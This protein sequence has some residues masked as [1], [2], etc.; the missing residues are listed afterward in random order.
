VPGTWGEE[1]VAGTGDVDWRKFFST[2]KQIRFT[3]NLVIEREAGTH[4]VA[5]ICAARDVVLE[6]AG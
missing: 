6:S 1:V 5:D 3:G 4:R 2:L